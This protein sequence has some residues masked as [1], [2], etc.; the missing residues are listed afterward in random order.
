MDKGGEINHKKEYVPEKFM[1]EN[2][3]TFNK[4]WFLV[5]MQS[6]IIGNRGA[7][8]IGTWSGCGEDSTRIR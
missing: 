2:V 6:F 1:L 7:F 3:S 4:V 5:L 8:D